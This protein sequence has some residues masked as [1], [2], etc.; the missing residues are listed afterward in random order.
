MSEVIQAEALSWLRDN[1]AAGGSSVISSLPDVSELDLDLE[2]WRE[3]FVGAARAVIRWLPEAGVAIFFQSDIR[4]TG[5]WIDKGYLIMRAAEAERANLI[6]HKIACR[7]PPGTA[8]FGRA[9]YSHML[10]IARDA[11]TSVRVAL[12]DVLPDAGAKT[13]T[14]GMGAAA[15]ELACRYLSAETRTRIVVDPFCGRGSVLA[16]ARSHG[17]EV[18][19]IEISAKRCRAARSLLSKIAP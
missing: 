2:A 4:H 10:C 6:W 14:R 5:V 1:P 3:W 19:G 8:S 7:L 18:I 16:T 15:C 13:W 9:S 17:F 12:P 11:P